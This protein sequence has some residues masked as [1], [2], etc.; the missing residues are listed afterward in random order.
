MLLFANFRVLCSCQG[1][2]YQPAT[3]WVGK[4]H[5]LECK[6]HVS[7]ASLLVILYHEC[8][9]LRP[10]FAFLCHFVLWWGNHF[11]IAQGSQPGI[12]GISC[13]I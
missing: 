6:S 10:K 8:G 3:S 13:S 9:L 2:K 11:F 12:K 5:I 4:E 1:E 7:V